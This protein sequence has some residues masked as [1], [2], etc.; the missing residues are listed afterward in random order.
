MN[1]SSVGLNAGGAGMTFVYPERLWL[2]A[3]WGLLALWAI[4]GRWRRRRGWADVAQRGRPPREGALW[5]LLAIGCLI[6]AIAQPKWGRLG[7][8]PAPGHDVVLMVDVSRSMGAEDAVP[9]RLG[10]AVDYAVKLVEALGEGPDN[11]A[12][13]V[14]FAGRGVLRCPLTENLGAVVDALRRLKPGSVQPGGTDLGA[15]LDAA[16]EALGTDEHAEG[17]TIVVISDGEDLAER[18]KPRLDRL[19]RREVIVYAV[20]IGDAEQGHPVPSGLGDGRPMVYQGKA[21]ESRRS[22]AALREVAEQTKG[23]VIPLGLSSGDPGVLYRKQIEPSARRR[24]QVPRASEMAERFPVFLAAAL[25]CLVAACWPP[26]R[27]WSWPWSGRIG[28][29]WSGPW[30]W[31]RRAGRRR[32]AEVAARAGVIAVAAGLIVGAGQPPEPAPAEPAARDLPAGSGRSATAREAVARGRSAYQAKQMD[33]ALAAFEEAV[34]SA[35]AAAIPRYDAASALF[36]L[37]RYEEARAR[38]EEARARADDDELKTKI[39][40][41]LGNTALVMGDVTGA[42]AAYDACIGSTARGAGLEVVRQDARINREFAYQQAQTPAIPQGQGPDDPSSSRRQDG[43]RSPDRPPGGEE[44]SAGGDDDAGPT[45]GG[46][47]GDDEADKDGRKRKPRRRRT[48]GGGGGRNTPPVGSGESP[49]DRL[50]AA[51]DD[52]R[53]AQESRRFPDEPPPASPGSDGRDW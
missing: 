48:G 15:G 20:T 29:G 50:D 3:A 21:V 30:P 17:Q 34:R 42:I 25:S 2:L 14:A 51:L 45:A 9:D 31:T 47:N 39:D 11:R 43:R 53:S 19:V 44:P 40:Y 16:L 41:A 23:L 27:G 13:V 33:D 10:V 7:P 28:W 37:G 6:V 12:A 8:A 36:Q 4:L 38:Y 22:D 46:P 1:E 18:W 35:P 32:Q 26:G 49:E 52:I 5:W 24:A